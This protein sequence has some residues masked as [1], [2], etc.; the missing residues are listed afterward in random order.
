MR[1]RL[2]LWR[3]G[4]GLGEHAASGIDPVQKE[5]RAEGGEEGE[6]R[7]AEKH[8]SFQMEVKWLERF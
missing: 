3:R 8:T 2:Y 5:G 6:R 4:W 7:G 1:L